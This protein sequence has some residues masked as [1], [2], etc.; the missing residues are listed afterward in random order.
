MNRYTATLLVASV[1]AFAMLLS[2]ATSQPPPA[3]RR[4]VF[5]SLKAGQSVTLKERVGLYE[6]G[7]TD[8]AGP[9]THKVVEVGD[10]FLVLKDEAGTVESRIPV[11]AVRHVVHVTTKAK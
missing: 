4:T 7:T 9:L 5:T 6:V 8:E 2:T 10:D 3:T 11:T 1:F